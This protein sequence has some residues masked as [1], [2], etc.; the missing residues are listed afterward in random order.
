MSGK[1]ETMEGGVA[2]QPK[3]RVKV[4]KP[5]LF[6]VILHNDDYTTMEFVIHILEELFHH[7]PAAAAQIMLKIHKKGRGVAGTFGRD[8]A[9]TKLVQVGQWARN[10]GHPLKATLEEA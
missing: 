9:E 2:T 4:K 5:R 1:D 3:S 7:P 6:N 10:S 8:I